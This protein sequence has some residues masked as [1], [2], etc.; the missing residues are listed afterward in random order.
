M[1]ANPVKS[2]ILKQS[3]EDLNQIMPRLANYLAEN[4]A[5][6]YNQEAFDSVINELQIS[7]SEDL[8]VG[9]IIVVNLNYKEENITEV[10][11]E[12]QRKIGSFNRGIEVTNANIHLNNV[13][14]ALSFLIQNP[15]WQPT[16]RLNGEALIKENQQKTL[17]KTLWLVV[18]G[19]LIAGIFIVWKIRTSRM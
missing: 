3:I 4:I 15:D 1:I 2:I 14:K 19:F 9:V 16:G 18:L 12:V 6:G 17:N 7:K 8:S 13:V 11:I 10:N 5:V